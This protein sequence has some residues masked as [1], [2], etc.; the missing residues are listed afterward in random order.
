M[1]ER[2]FGLIAGAPSSADAAT[3]AKIRGYTRGLSRNPVIPGAPDTWAIARAFMASGEEAYPIGWRDIENDVPFAAHML[4]LLGVGRGDFLFFAYL[5][6][7]SGQSWPWLKAGFDRGAK[8]ATGMPTQW[9]AYRLEMYLR[10]FK[11]RLA[12]GI[13]AGT[14]DGLA[15]AGHDIGK[16]LGAADRIVA[17]PDACVRLRAAGLKPWRLHWIGPILAVDP[18]DGSG[19]HFDHGQWRLEADAEGRILVSNIGERM[20]PFARADT[21]ARGAVRPV[22]GEP[23]LFVEAAA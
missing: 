14:L 23:R 8:L 15:G 21:G 13:S 2:Y 1:N 22:D 10:L 6:S 18:C 9:D 7:Q 17:L 20:T 12:F 16:V 3:L 4:D 5:Y 19:A 11:V